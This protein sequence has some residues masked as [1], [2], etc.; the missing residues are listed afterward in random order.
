MS[1]SDRAHVRWRGRTGRSARD[2]LYHPRQNPSRCFARLRAGPDRN[3]QSATIDPQRHL[4]PPRPHRLHL[5]AAGGGEF[6]RRPHAHLVGCI[7]LALAAFD[8]RQRRDHEGHAGGSELVEFIRE[9]F[10]A[11]RP[12]PHWPVIEAIEALEREFGV[13]V[14]AASQACVWDALR[15]VGVNDR[16]SGYG[17]LLREF[18]PRGIGN[19]ISGCPPLARRSS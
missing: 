9:Y 2:F 18:Y 11:E 12:S 17:R 14:M 4:R 16:I 1:F 3:D 6:T 8:H 5:P 10:R 15:L 13:T 7:D 19:V